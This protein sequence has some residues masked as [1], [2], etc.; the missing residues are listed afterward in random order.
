MNLKLFKQLRN[1]FARMKHPQHF[2]MA[3]I[4]IKTDCGAAMCFIG[5]TLDLAGYRMRL[6]SKYG[7]VGSDAWHSDYQFIRPDGLVVGSPFE[8]AQELL[9]IDYDTARE[10]FEAWHLKTPKQAVEYLDK[11]IAEAK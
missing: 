8:E 5:H 1:R 7:R 3:Q 11:L 6:K 10:T 9:E 4:A 2:R